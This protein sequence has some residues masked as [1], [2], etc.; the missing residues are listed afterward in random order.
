MMAEAIQEVSLLTVEEA[1]KLTRL[2][3]STL[4]D[5]ILHRRISVVKLGR[6]VFIK[7]DEVVKL[8]D[9]SVVP[10]VPKS[11]AARE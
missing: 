10:A 2:R 5:W 6:R 11:K 1:S 4:R 9:S 8:I 3:S 7:R